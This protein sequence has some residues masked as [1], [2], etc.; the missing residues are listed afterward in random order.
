MDLNLSKILYK[1]NQRIS[2]DVILKKKTNYS[3]RI[4]ILS[5]GLHNLDKLLGGGFRSEKL[6]IIFG[7]YSTGKTQ[8]CHQLCVESYKKF[9]SSIFIDTE[10]TFR[11]ERIIQIADAQKLNP[12]NVLKSILVTKTLSNSMFLLNLQ[13]VENMI[14]SNKYKVILID[15]I[16]K[17][18][19]LEQ[20]ND[21]I[22][23]YKAKTNFLKILKY[24][25]DLTN[26]Y[27]IITICSAQVSP[28]FI[29]NNIIAENPVGIQYLNHFCSEFLYLTMQGESIG[30]AHL[31]NSFSLAEEK[32]VFEIKSEGIKDCD[33]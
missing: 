7:K 8:L 2:T 4:N 27:N 12:N 23:F 20:S 9:A 14:K 18:Y 33:I 28:I 32:A 10:N 11:P 6:Y 19:R 1:T 21:E 17:Y 3:E 26:S 30:N 16:N 15:S 13:N 22:S 31:V 24:L 25:N 5:S 29:A